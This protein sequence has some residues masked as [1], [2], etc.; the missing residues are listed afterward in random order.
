MRWLIGTVLAGLLTLASIFAHRHTPLQ[1]RQNNEGIKLRWGRAVQNHQDKVPRR[2]VISRRRWRK[3]HRDCQ[4]P[5]KV[6]KRGQWRF[7][8]REHFIQRQITR[9]RVGF[10]AEQMMLGDKTNFKVGL[11]VWFRI[12][13]IVKTVG[14]GDISREKQL[15][16]DFVEYARSV[17]QAHLLTL[18]HDNISLTEIADSTQLLLVTWLKEYGITVDSVR[19]TQ[20]SPSWLSEDVLLAEKRVDLIESLGQSHNFNLNSPTALVLLSRGGLNVPAGELEATA[21]STDD[22]E[23][24]EEATGTSGQVVHLPQQPSAKTH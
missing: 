15:E 21:V 18:S 12:T 4:C 11:S 17:T 2:R 14:Y 1:I 16:E 10:A 9:Q 24:P 22:A 19:V 20:F 8:F 23:S 3:A 7:P 6:Y 13:D 5:P